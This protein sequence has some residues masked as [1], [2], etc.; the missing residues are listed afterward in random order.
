MNQSENRAYIYQIELNSNQTNDARIIASNF[1]ENGSKVLDV[2]CACGDFGYYLSNDKKC[3]V[4]GMEYDH[5]SIQVALTKNIFQKINQVD[6][7][8]YDTNEHPEYINQFDYI[9]LLDVLEH[10][11]FPEKSLLQLKPY[12]K[13]NGYFIVSLPN[14]SFG[15]IKITLLNDDFEYTEM[16]ILDKTHLR[17]FTYKTIAKF[18]ASLNFEIIEC[19]VKVSGLTASMKNIPL[20]TRKYILKNPH[21]F[22]YQYVLKIKVSSLTKEALSTHNR[23][24]MDIQKSDIKYELNK[25]KRDTFIR[26]LL[27]VDSKRRKYIKSIYNKFKDKK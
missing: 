12:I 16:G 3:T 5:E 17:F 6:L 23:A 27:P 21:S 9:T 26:S 25:I 1:I 4:Y 24:K 22:A 19:K 8:I 11:I 13:E 15:D 14:I 7:N 20:M 18:F 10:T 2:G